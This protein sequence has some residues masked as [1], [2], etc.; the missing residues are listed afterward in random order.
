[1]IRFKPE[2]NPRNVHP[3]IWVAVGVVSHIRK[4]INKTD[5]WVTS[6]NDGSHGA[7][8]LHYLRNSADQL[9]RA[10]DFRIHDLAKPYWIAFFDNVRDGLPEGYDVVLHDGSD[11]VA[12]HLHV[13]FQPKANE[14]DIFAKWQFGVFHADATRF[15]TT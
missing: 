3:S 4:T 6:M 1:M 2:V 5:T 12:P 8:S 10:V 11:G 15:K 7:G 9:C 14:T 13:E